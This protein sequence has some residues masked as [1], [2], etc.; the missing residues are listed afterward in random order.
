MFKLSTIQEQAA[1][2]SALKLAAAYNDISNKGVN[3]NAPT[4][5]PE[6]RL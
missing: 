3:V 5:A 4:S 6:A 2:P 1:A